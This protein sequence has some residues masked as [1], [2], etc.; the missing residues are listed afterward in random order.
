LPKSSW[1]L[2]MFF[3]CSM[4]MTQKKII[5]QWERNNLWQWEIRTVWKWGTHHIFP[6]KSI[7]DFV[8]LKI[9]S[10]ISSKST[11]V[12][13][14]PFFWDIPTFIWHLPQL[15]HTFVPLPASKIC[16]EHFGYRCRWSSP[17]GPPH[18][19]HG[20]WN[21][22]RRKSQVGAG[23]GDVVV[24]AWCLGWKCQ[25]FV[26]HNSSETPGVGAK[27][28][29]QKAHDL[30]GRW[31]R[32]KLL[33]QKQSVTITGVDPAWRL[34]SPHAP[35]AMGRT[36]VWSERPVSWKSWDENSASF[37]KHWH[38]LKRKTWRITIKSIHMFRLAQTYPAL[39][40]NLYTSICK[41]I[42][43][44]QLTGSKMRP[45]TLGLIDHSKFWKG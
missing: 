11:L 4:G 20:A 2:L 42:P 36:V 14:W 34:I 45:V 13:R 39:F 31:A 17:W 30:S 15:H 27:K 16:P 33:Q 21:A 12:G 3:A 19:Y 38:Y 18:R 5:H 28:I 22:W 40:I 43:F 41:R 32:F 23:V 24:S 8:P 35:P 9:A 37:T 1:N 44:Q 6:P 25:G 10:I 7:K 26:E 29:S